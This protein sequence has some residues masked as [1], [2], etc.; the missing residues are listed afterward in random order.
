M[1][2][3]DFCYA[4]EPRYVHRCERFAL[5]PEPAVGFHGYV[6]TDGEWAACEEC[7]QCLI[8][9]ADRALMARSMTGEKHFTDNRPSESDGVYKMKVLQAF[10]DRYQ[11]EW[12]PE[13]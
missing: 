8:A 3:C 6:D 11:G 4:P 7:H 13:S 10:L 2:I 12:A 5:A 1:D 9:R